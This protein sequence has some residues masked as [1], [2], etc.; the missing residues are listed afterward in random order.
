MEHQVRVLAHCAIIVLEGTSPAHGNRFAQVARGQS[1]LNATHSGLG[2]HLAGM[3][4]DLTDEEA[5]LHQ[6]PAAGAGLDHGYYPSAFGLTAIFPGADDDLTN[7][8]SAPI[9]GDRPT[10]SFAIGLT[11]GISIRDPVRDIASEPVT[12][13]TISIHLPEDRLILD[14][15]VQQTP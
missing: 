3:T 7:T 11:R 9:A 4:L 13:T 5:R 1:W 12:G 15:S 8:L 2:P 6:A 10:K 14:A